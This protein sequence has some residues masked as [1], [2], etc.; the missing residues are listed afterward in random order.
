MPDVRTCLDDK[1]ALGMWP[2]GSVMRA[3]R[4]FRLT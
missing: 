4:S 3:L 2:D 1:C